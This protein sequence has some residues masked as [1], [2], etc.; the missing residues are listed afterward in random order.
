MK[1]DQKA[2]RFIE[3]EPG[4]FI[5][6]ANICKVSILQVKKTVSVAYRVTVFEQDQLRSEYYFHEI[7][8]YYNYN[9]AREVALMII[10]KCGGLVPWIPEAEGE[11]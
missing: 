9:E 7:G 8:D 4:L 3:I 1:R 10:E 2:G 11:K 6:V 5:E